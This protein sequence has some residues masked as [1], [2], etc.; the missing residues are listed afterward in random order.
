MAKVKPGSL[1]SLLRGIRNDIGLASNVFET[2]EKREFDYDTDL[3]KNVKEFEKSSN[4]FYFLSRYIIV[5]VEDFANSPVDRDIILAAYGL[6]TGYTSSEV[7][8]RH[9]QYCQD[10]GISKNERFIPLNKYWLERNISKNLNSKENAAIK[11]LA[12]R[13]ENELTNNGKLNYTKNALELMGKPYPP[14]N[15][16]LGEGHGYRQYNDGGKVFYI[17]LTN[18]ELRQLASNVSVNFQKEASLPVDRANKPNIAQPKEPTDGIIDFPPGADDITI[19]ISFLRKKIREI[20]K[21]EARLEWDE[22]QLKKFTIT[23][24]SIILLCVGTIYVL[25]HYS[26]IVKESVNTVFDESP[27][28][29]NWNI[30]N[31]TPLNPTNNGMVQGAKKEFYDNLFNEQLPLIQ[32]RKESELWHER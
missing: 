27:E 24:L 1:E 15:Y 12:E 21:G 28:P 22:N 3:N 13:L 14:P 5:V 29:K 32:A 19:F 16:M 20:P 9:D 26:Y 23:S 17:P 6:L 4:E 10:I 18:K 2:L 31:D 30:Y 8:D 11:K 7:Q 25:D